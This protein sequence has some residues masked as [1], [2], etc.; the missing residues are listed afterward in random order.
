MPNPILFL[1]LALAFLA[2]GCDSDGDTPPDPPVASSAAGLV[3]IESATDFDAT[4]AALLQALDAAGPVTTV[5]NVDH[6][7]NAPADL[8]LPPTRVVLFGNPLVGTP[9]MQANQQAGIDLPQKMLVYTDADGT[10]L[11]GYN[12]TDYLVQ[13]HGVGGVAALG[14]IRNVLERFADEAGGEGTPSVSTDSVALNEGLVRVQSNAD[15]ETTYAR[16]RAAVTA[17]PNLSIVAE[18]DHAADAASANLEL[19][20]TKLIVFG[21]PALGTP[22]MQATQTIG[23]DLPQK[24]LVYTDADGGTFVL[25]NDPQYLADRH[26]ATGV[27]EQVGM[28]QT[29]LSGL[30]TTAT[31][32]Q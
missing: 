13:R 20:P 15:A 9:L 5:A 24:M 18:V 8:P 6:S 29:A 22:L 4:S 17:N 3:L 30:A 28:I 23:I 16:L 10:T 2:T 26:G 25:Y 21:N 7:A 27:G 1:L 12:S 14:Q 31:T 11:I 19:R 32:G